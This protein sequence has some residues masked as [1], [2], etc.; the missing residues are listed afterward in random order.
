MSHNQTYTNEL[1]FFWGE[2]VLSILGWMKTY[3]YTFVTSD[4]GCSG[5]C[6]GNL[7]SKPRP[8]PAASKSAAPLLAT[9][10]SSVPLAALDD[11]IISH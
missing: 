6:E 2:G 4:V 5:I 8:L 3:L 11:G 10:Q 9:L 1:L 7:C